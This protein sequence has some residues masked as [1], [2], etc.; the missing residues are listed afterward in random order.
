MASCLIQRANSFKFGVAIRIWFVKMEGKFFLPLFLFLILL[1]DS[2]CLLL[3]KAYPK[4]KKYS[5]GGDAGEALFL[6]TFIEKGDIEKARQLAI[7]NL[8]EIKTPSYAGYFTV[9]KTYNSNL[10]FWYFPAATEA[11]DTP[12]LLW[13]QGN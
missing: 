5:D 8:K 7:V 9:N 3:N 4:F 10:F 12:V 6:T 2:E 1:V 13:L 11:K